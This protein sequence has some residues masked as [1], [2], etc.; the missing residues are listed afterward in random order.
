MALG[1]GVHYY[2]GATLARLDAQIAF[3]T[4]PTRPQNIRLPADKND[5]THT[6]G[7]ILRGLKALHLE[8]D[9]AGAKFL[10]RGVLLD[11]RSCLTIIDTDVGIPL[12]GTR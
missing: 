4:L 6:P 1:E 11:R 5:L 10:S 2:L 8:L 12:L 9:P 7:F 3:E